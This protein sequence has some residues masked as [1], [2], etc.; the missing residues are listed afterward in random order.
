MEYY[1]ISLITSIIIFIIIQMV[2]YNNHKKNLENEENVYEEE[3][4][5]LFKIS[6]ILLFLIIYLVFTIGFF[7][8]KPSLPSFL[9]FSLLAN[10]NS[11][12]GGNNGN[13]NNGN[14]NV[15][16]EI[17]PTVIS[18]ITD[19]FETGFAPFN[20]DDDSLSSMSSNEN[21]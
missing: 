17:D 12:S 5:N 11:Q 2:E 8:L 6:N 10:D 18:K 1:I 21:T 15:S 14:T 3:P 20:S 9:N 7:Y 4:Y 16:E 19:N 13:G